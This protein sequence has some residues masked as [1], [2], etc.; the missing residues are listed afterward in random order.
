[1]EGRLTGL[2]CVPTNIVAGNEAYLQIFFTTE[3]ATTAE[4]DIHIAL[5]VGFGLYALCVFDHLPAYH[6][7]TLANK[8]T[9]I[10]HPTYR[11]EFVR[12][13]A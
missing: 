10:S 4:T 3:Q 9:G 1:M 2:S 5:P 12:C 11:L 8:L 13:E 7:A 6:Y